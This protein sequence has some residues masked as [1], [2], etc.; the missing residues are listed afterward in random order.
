MHLGSQTRS[1]AG[2][3]PSGCSQADAGS[4]LSP[5]PPGDRDVRLVAYQV[6]AT[7]RAQFDTLLWQV[8]TL[9]F[10]AQAFL[11]T[12]AL[13]S[14][15]PWS[16]YMSSSLSLTIT[17]LSI[18]LMARHRQTELMDS[19]LLETIERDF[20]HID[21]WKVHGRGFVERRNAT[22][23]LRVRGLNW[24]PLC[25]QYPVWVVG[26]MLFGVGAVLIILRT[27][28]AISW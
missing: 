14:G 9:S 13:G 5:V 1:Q 23:D 27:A 8:P 2:V 6:L 15:D 12:I 16:K 26:L 21:D 10:T 20:F 19:L 7:R 22:Q 4:N 28:G 25:R 17:V 18:L 11:F 3:Q 24:I